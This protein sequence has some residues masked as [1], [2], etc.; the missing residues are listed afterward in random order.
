MPLRGAN[1]V[2]FA[3]IRQQ[4]IYIATPELLLLYNISCHQTE[5]VFSLPAR[6]VGGCFQNDDLWLVFEQPLVVCF[7]VICDQKQKSFTVKQQKV[8]PMAASGIVMLNNI[9]CLYADGRIW[10]NRLDDEPSIIKL[11]LTELTTL[12]SV[13]EESF[14]VNVLQHSEKQDLLKDRNY[15]VLKYELEAIHDFSKT[16]LHSQEAFV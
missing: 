1:H 4:M 8:L 9:A 3:Y 10:F 5:A 15:Q 16:S 6:A 14:Y 13:K 7:G 2:I 11:R 12:D